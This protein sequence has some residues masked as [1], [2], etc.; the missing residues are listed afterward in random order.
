MIHN[1]TPAL[2]PASSPAHE[3]SCHGTPAGLGFIGVAPSLTDSL[4][5]KIILAIALAA[6]I[7]FEKFSHDSR[8]H[9]GTTYKR[10]AGARAARRL[11]Y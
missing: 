10:R 5:W 6:Y 2:L 4:D 1:T 9:A 3:C 11:D 8:T 7:V